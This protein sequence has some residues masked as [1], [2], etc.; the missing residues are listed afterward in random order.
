MGRTARGV[1]GIKLKPEDYVIGMA[2][3]SEEGTL[4]TVTENGYGKRT[5]FEEYRDQSRGGMGI[6]TY[7]ITEKT[8]Q[9]VGM[10][11]VTPQDDIMLIN[12]E[13]VIIRMSAADISEYKRSTQGVRLIKMD[14]GIKVVSM[15]ITDHEEEEE[16][17]E[18][19]TQP[20]Q[21]IEEPIE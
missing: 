1:R 17:A 9:L 6:T 16:S 19:E 13:G 2:R 21:I 4:L 14:E 15:A 20:P 12:T 8:G 18:E 5:G 3:V 11:T 7:K 10:E